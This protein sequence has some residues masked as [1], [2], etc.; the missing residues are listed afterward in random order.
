MALLP[1]LRLALLPLDPREVDR[2][3]EAVAAGMG[4]R[5]EQMAARFSIGEGEML[6]NLALDLE[7]ALLLERDGVA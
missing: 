1:H 2:L 7:M 6:A 5:P 3:G 4:A